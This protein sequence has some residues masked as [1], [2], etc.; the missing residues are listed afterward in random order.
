MILWRSTL[1]RPRLQP[2]AHAPDAG[3]RPIST[4]GLAARRSSS[5]FVELIQIKAPA[6]RATDRTPMPRHPLARDVVVVVAIKL[7]LLIAA[8]TFLFGPGQRPRIDAGSIATRL[9][10]SKDIS[11][12]P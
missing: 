1:S 12:Q 6:R 4:A 9:I 7:A 5:S 11:R 2:S 3:L 10:D 8:A